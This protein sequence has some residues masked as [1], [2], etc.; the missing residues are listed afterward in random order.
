[1]RRAD[2]IFYSSYF[3]RILECV[4]AKTKIIIIS[5]GSILIW[6]NLSLK[7]W[8]VLMFFGETDLV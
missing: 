7:K 8:T 3:A 1:L 4:E 2:V 5:I 6:I